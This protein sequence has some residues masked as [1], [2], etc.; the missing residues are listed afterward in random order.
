[1]DS[2]KKA[3]TL[4]FVPVNFFHYKI[5][6]DNAEETKLLKSRSKCD[7]FNVLSE[8]KLKQASLAANRKQTFSSEITLKTA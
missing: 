6:Y 5:R 7:V 1:M 2:F 8:I 3:A 4:I